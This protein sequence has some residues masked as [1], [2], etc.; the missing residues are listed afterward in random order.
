MKFILFLNY[1]AELIFAEAIQMNQRV[2]P[3]TKSV[4]PS[5]ICQQYWPTANVTPGWTAL[6][7]EVR[8]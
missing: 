5:A 1:N 2:K 4:H 7:L 6:L 8:M 3:E